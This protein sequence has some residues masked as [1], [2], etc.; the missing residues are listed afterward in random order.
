MNTLEYVTSIA[1]SVANE[2]QKIVLDEDTDLLAQ[3]DLDSL[4]M[5]EIMDTLEKQ[6]RATLFDVI[7]L[8]EINTPRKLAEYIDRTLQQKPGP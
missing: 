1:R 4:A 5:L 3:A 2:S 6:Y 8:N 7:D